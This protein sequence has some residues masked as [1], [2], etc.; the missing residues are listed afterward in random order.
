MGRMRNAV[1]VVFVVRAMSREWRKSVR[2]KQREYR[3]GTGFCLRRRK[4]PQ[5]VCEQTQRARL[6]VDQSV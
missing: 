1:G 4:R 2:K 3:L 6:E 5:L